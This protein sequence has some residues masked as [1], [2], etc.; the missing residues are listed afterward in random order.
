MSTAADSD[1]SAAG[2]F[3]R[4][5]QPLVGQESRC[6]ARTWAGVRHASRFRGR[7]LSLCAIA[8]RCSAECTDRSVP[9]GKYQGSEMARHDE[10]AHLLSDGIYFAEPGRPWQRGSNENT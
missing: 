1:P 7:V 2:A 5:S 10:I 4:W 3:G 8:A 6:A 9:F